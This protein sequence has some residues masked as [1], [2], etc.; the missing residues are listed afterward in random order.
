MKLLICTQKMDKNDPILGFFHRWVEEFAKK[1]EGVI[2]ICLKEGEHELPENVRVLSLGKERGVS[3]IK[4]L[5]RFYRFLFKERKNYDAV[6]VHMNTVYV[7]LGGLLWRL[8]RKKVGLWYAHGHTGFF[9]KLSE[10]ITNIIFT[11]TKKGCR[12]HS[13]KVK[14][15]GQGIDTNYF[16]PEDKREK[17]EAFT[18][19]TVGRISPVKDYETMIEAMGIL[20]QKNINYLLEIIGGAESREEKD[21]QE[22]LK[23]QVKEKNLEKKIIFKGPLSNTDILEDLQSSD[24]FISTSLTGS[25]DKAVLEAMATGTPASTCN[26]AFDELLADEKNLLLF[27]KKSKNELSEKLLSLYTLGDKERQSLGGRLREKVVKNHSLPTLIDKIIR[28]YNAEI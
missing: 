28:N 21:Y 14:I 5:F 20:S 27:R 23:D 25:M 17:N 26:E 24:V 12:L 6:F 16:H 10:K 2:V 13:S 7:L 9:L 22:K 4:Y 19:I 3:R 18:L 8:W 15:V 1:C 11:S